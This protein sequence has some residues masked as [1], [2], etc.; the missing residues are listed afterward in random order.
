MKPSRFEWMGRLAMPMAMVIMLGAAPLPVHALEV[1]QLMGWL[2]QTKE[3]TATF[4]EERT[5]QGFD[6]PLV[7][8]GELSFKAPDQFERRTLQPSPES[9]SVNGNTMTL[10]RGKQK[11]TMALDAAPEAAAIVSAI[12]GTLTGDGTTLA[13]HYQVAAR[14][15][16]DRWLLDLVPRDAQLAANVRNLQLQGSKGVVNSVEIWFASGDRSLMKIV[17]MV[18]AVKRP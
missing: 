17:P 18:A 14:G 11:R 6:A 9:M 4:V 8:R 3:G 10:V 15:N 1:Q 5:V 7:T 2:A 13:Q 16:G 12:R